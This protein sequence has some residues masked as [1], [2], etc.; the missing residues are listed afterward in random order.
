MINS[1][2]YLPTVD[3]IAVSASILCGVHCLFLPL[4]VVVS[5]TIAATIFGQESFHQILVFF[6]IPISV[7]GLFMGCRKHKNKFVAL[8]GLVGLMTLGLAASL[9]HSMLGE[10]G[11]TILTLIGSLAIASSHVRNYLLCR[12]LDSCS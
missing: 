9:G 5:P 1:E 3:K 4:L 8:L 10:S 6:I 7:I 2:N 12:Q 11:E